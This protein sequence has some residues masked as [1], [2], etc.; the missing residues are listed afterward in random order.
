MEIVPRLMQ[1]SLLSI[2]K[3]A[4]VNYLTVFTPKEVQILGRDR[5]TIENTME[6][7]LQKWKDLQTGL[8]SIPILPEQ[9]KEH[10]KPQEEA[11]ELNPPNQDQMVNNVYEFPSMKQ[12]ICYHH[13]TAGFQTKASWLRAIKA[14]F[15]ATW[16]M[17]TATA[18]NKHFLESEE[19][20]KGP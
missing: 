2:K 20:H 4:E 8:W 10:S 12:I 3:F 11:T 13:A 18:T 14:R 15:Y 19:T 9:N 5:T 6:P 16:P 17:L 7:I 1:N